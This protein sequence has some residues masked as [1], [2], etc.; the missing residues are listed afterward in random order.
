MIWE[1]QWCV[2]FPRYE[3]LFAID[4]QEAICVFNNYS[5]VKKGSDILLDIPKKNMIQFSW[6]EWSISFSVRPINILIFKNSNNI[7]HL[8]IILFTTYIIIITINTYKIIIMWTTLSINIIS[9]ILSLSLFF[10]PYLFKTVS[11]PK[12]IL[13]GDGESIIFFP[14]KYSY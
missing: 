13:F 6:D 5:S 10:F 11:D 7:L 12:F 3:L 2:S 9:T 4:I 14:H 8:H 1:F